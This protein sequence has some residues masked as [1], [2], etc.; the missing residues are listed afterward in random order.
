MY[1]TTPTANAAS[2]CRSGNEAQMHRFACGLACGLS[3]GFHSAGRHVVVILRAALFH[4]PVVILRAAV[5]R[6]EIFATGRG[7]DVG[8]AGQ[9][10]MAFLLLAW[11]MVGTTHVR[12]TG[13]NGLAAMGAGITT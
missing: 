3:V 1:I 8:C 11:C 6:G 9:Y 13:R 12:C 7:W 2:A 10:Q 5:P 4:S